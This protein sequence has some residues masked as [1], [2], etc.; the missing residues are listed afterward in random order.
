MKHRTKRLIRKNAEFAALCLLGPLGG[1]IHAKRWPGEATFTNRV[2][3]P[4]LLGAKPV[5]KYDAK[6]G[7]SL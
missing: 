1:G 7:R 5:A 3:W 4:P 6:R 2:T